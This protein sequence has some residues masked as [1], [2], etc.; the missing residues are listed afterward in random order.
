M[1]WV[2]RML[3]YNFENLACLF[4]KKSPGIFVGHRKR[5]YR[6]T[7]IKII[8]DITCME[9]SYVVVRL[10]DTLSLMNGCI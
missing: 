4:N 10:L 5:S 6:R 9:G 8:R 1:E 2:C 7:F 3:I